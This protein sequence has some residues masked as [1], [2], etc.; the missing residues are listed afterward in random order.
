MGRGWPIA[1]LSH[2]KALRVLVVAYMHDT[3]WVTGRCAQ[4]KSLH[5][6]PDRL[7]R[8]MPYGN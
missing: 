8:P 3:Y 7:R 1:L 4:P 6:V 2:L 5:F